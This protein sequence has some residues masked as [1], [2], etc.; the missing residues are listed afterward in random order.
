MAYCPTDAKKAHQAVPSKEQQRGALLPPYAKTH[1]ME[2]SASFDGGSTSARP[3]G[4][5]N[6][7]TTVQ[8]LPSSSVNIESSMAA[9]STLPW[10]WR[11]LRR[12][13][14]RSPCRAWTPLPGQSQR[15][16]M[17]I[18]G[19]SGWRSWSTR[20]WWRARHKAGAGRTRPVGRVLRGRDHFDEDV[21]RPY[22]GT[23]W[24]ITAMRFS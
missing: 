5:Y 7:C 4:W 24:S 23:G 2:S 22:S 21:V 8:S 11:P 18:T 9:R 16:R 6:A 12:P 19:T 10:R 20:V 17:V 15:L 14:R 3:V 1:S 13:R